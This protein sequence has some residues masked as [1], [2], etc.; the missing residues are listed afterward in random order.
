M[1]DNLY[2]SA[3][4]KF[5]PTGLGRFAKLA[6]SGEFISFA[7]GIP[8]NDLLPAKEINDILSNINITY[9]DEITQYSSLKGNIEL[10]DTIKNIF[11]K[12]TKI[13][14]NNILI[15]NGSQQSIDLLTKLF[16]DNHSYIA[17]SKFS[18]VGALN[19]FKFFHANL[20]HI[21]IND[22]GISIQ[23]LEKS[24]KH[25]RIKFI[26]VIPDHQNP[27]SSTMPIENRIKLTELANKYNFV[28]I[29]D[30]AYSFL[31]FDNVIMPSI[32]QLDKYHNTISLYSFSKILC[33]NL[34]MS[35]IVGP[36]KIINKLQ[37]IKQISDLSISGIHQCIVLEYL[38]Q[39]EIN[40]HIENLQKKYKIKKDLMNNMLE[41]YFKNNTKVNWTNPSGGFFIWLT[42]ND[43]HIGTLMDNCIQRKV[44]FA[45]GKIFYKQKKAQNIRLNF[46]YPANKE[47]IEGIEILSQEIQK[48]LAKN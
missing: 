44:I 18:Y 35:W 39:H 15:S 42:I 6:T 2:S 24:L 30:C 45:D 21:D 4:Y 20:I 38:K 28:I 23:H 46:T 29:E 37:H 17:V 33:P 31:S 25:K 27:T 41:K 5:T 36:V 32:Y 40:T 1:I 8:P 48:L 9:M 7:G 19:T 3:T 11:H 10:I 43:I 13:N 22:D 47:I 16:I 12:N 34:R 26:Y 14:E